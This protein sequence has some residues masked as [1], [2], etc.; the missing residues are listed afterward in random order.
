MK[1]EDFF[2]IKGLGKAVDKKVKSCHECKNLILPNQERN[3]EKVKIREIGEIGLVD[4]I[5]KTVNRETRKWLFASGSLTRFFKLYPI[6]G[7]RIT[8]NF[9]DQ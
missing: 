1:V 9:I 2:Y 3:F 8:R 5:H 6:T 7:S 4:E